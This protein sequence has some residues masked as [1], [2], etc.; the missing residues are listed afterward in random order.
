MTRMIYSLPWLL[1]FLLLF[2]FQS[3]R[4]QIWTPGDSLSTLDSDTARIDPFRNNTLNLTGED[5]V[6]ASFPNSWP[7]FG[8]KARVAIGGYVKVDYIQ[9]FDGSYDRFQYEI[10][11]VPVSGDGR[12][13]QSGYMNLHG[14]ESRI[15]ID[16][17][18]ITSI[19]R[20]LQVFF[21]LDFFNLDRGPFNQSPRLRHFYGVVGRLLI[22]RTWGTQSDLY[23]VPTT[24]D[25]AAGD[26]LTGTRRAQVRYENSWTDQMKY[27]VALEK[28]EFPGIEANEQPGQASQLL[29]M[30]VGRITR[31][32]QNGGRIMLG[33]S[34]FQLRWDGLNQ[35]P[36]EE[37]FGWGVSFSG[38][39]YFT[40]KKHYVRWITSYGQG[41]GSNVIALLGT[42]GSAILNDQGELETMPTWNVGAGIS[43]NLSEILVL[44]VNTDW[45]GL[46]APSFRDTHA[47][48][49]GGANHAT[50]IWSPLKSINAGI[51]YMILTRT[52]TG[53]EHGTGQRL[54][55]MIKYIF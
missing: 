39:S 46:D 10:E 22:G 40:R 26:A 52:N 44:N 19:G 47:L 27:A 23:A 4:A 17:R 49:S 55:L 7:V 53:D 42:G 35:I 51:E 50:L 34:A 32:L 43:L 21:E 36:N 33:A 14:R 54:Q 11:D 30:A 24:I 38:R 18:S 6:D 16:F 3:A 41:W 29:P 1:C 37:A 9:D 48:K 45:F 12:L 28:L 25:F 13:E 15:N 5:L 2:N 20:P 8:T 31:E